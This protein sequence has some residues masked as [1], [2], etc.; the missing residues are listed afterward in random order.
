MR[1]IVLSLALIVSFITSMF[2]LNSCFID[3]DTSIAKG[4][5][6][7]LISALQNKDHAAIKALF[8]S[9]K[10]AD[11]E[12][13]DESIDELLAYYEGDYV[14]Q[15]GGGPATLSGKDGRLVYKYYLM[16]NDI[17]TTVRV[18]RI[19]LKWY[20]TDTANAGNVGIWQLFILK[21]E[22]DPNQE[23]SYGGDGT[24]SPGIYI[25]RIYDRSS[26]DTE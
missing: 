21:K 1:K 12:N 25:G 6:D 19:A 20:I 16:S 24:I 22:D 7:Q 4:K 18:Y 13:F 2:L 14:S 17:T 15:T 9:N 23:Y 10:I 8:A 5:R 11:I 26:E 3:T